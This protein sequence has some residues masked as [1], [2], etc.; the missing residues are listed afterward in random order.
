MTDAKKVSILEQLLDE[1]DEQIKQLQ[2]E[3]A[4]LQKIIENYSDGYSDINEL[5][6]LINEIR[7]Q[8]KEYKDITNVYTHLTNEYRKEMRSFMR[9]QKI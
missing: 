6:V 4:E 9:K 2:E 8:S 5:R 3:N 1:R 7:K